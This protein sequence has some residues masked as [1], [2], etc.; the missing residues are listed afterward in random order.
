MPKWVAIIMAILCSLT[1]ASITFGVTQLNNIGQIK[2]VAADVRVSRA[3]LVALQE[4][5]KLLRKQVDDDNARNE[6]RIAHIITLMEANQKTEQEFINLLKVQNELLSR[7]I[8]P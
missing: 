8:R 2:D 5:Q 7:Q 3:N 6:Q 4:D 1:T